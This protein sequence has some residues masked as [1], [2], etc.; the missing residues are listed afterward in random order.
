MLKNLIY[1]LLFFFSLQTAVAGNPGDTKSKEK[2]AERTVM[3]KVT[4]ASG[5][6]L[7]GA[8][9]IVEETGETVYTDWEGNF[10]LKI[11]TDKDYSISVN[12]IGFKPVQL[13]SS[14][15]LLFAELT[16]SPL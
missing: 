9:I 8:K 10:V 1:I 5:E 11:K 14:S 7:I 13:K 3:A 2:V 6:A 15:V 12:T 16:L 4:D